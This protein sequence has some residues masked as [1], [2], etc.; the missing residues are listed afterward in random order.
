MNT[1]WKLNSHS[2]KYKIATLF[3]YY[4]LRECLI[5]QLYPYAA[6]IATL[7]IASKIFV[8]ERITK[9]ILYLKLYENVVYGICPKVL[10]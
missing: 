4:S 7:M 2:N 6:Q 10:A 8:R 5:N 9:E 3:I 1:K